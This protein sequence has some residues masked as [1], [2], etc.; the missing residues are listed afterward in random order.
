MLISTLCTFHSS[1]IEQSV[2][3]Y[4]IVNLSTQQVHTQ[5]VM[6]LCLQWTTSAAEEQIRR[7]KNKEDTE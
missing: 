1:S 2:T 7:I 4:I 6:G 5:E 3:M